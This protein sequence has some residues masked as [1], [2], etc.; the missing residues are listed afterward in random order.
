MGPGPTTPPEWTRSSSRRTDPAVLVAGTPPGAAQP[1]ATGSLPG[2]F[3]ATP[4]AG[5]IPGVGSG[6]VVTVRFTPAAATD[7]TRATAS[8][9][10]AVVAA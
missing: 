2:T 7:S 6:P 10:I 8:V 5:T 3:V 1:N 9:G 4:A